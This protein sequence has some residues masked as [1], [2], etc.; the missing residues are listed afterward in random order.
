MSMSILEAM[1][2]GLPIVAT[3]VGDNRCLVEDGI[4]CGFVVPPNN[5]NELAKALQT[6]ATDEPTRSAHSNASVQKH[7]QLFS[8]KNMIKKYEALYEQLL[9]HSTGI[10]S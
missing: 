4:R 3:D 2:I 5:P 9:A 8:I 1:S 7:G 6:Y 10:L